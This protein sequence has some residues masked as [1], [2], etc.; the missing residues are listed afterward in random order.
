MK[1]IATLL[2]TFT[3]VNIL[4]GVIKYALFG[5]SYPIVGP[6]WANTISVVV[7]TLFQYL[8]YS[9]V[10]WRN[11]K[12]KNSFIK[13]LILEIPITLAEITLFPILRLLPIWE[14][15]LNAIGINSILANGYLA[16]FIFGFLMWLIGISFHNYITF[17]N[18]QN[19]IS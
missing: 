8:G 9:K 7:S 6:N 3:I 12:T 1:R 15:A 4:C 11:R 13:F 2:G 17:K 10:T 19:G 16:L 5:L 14:N 18:S